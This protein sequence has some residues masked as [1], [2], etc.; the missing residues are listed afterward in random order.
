MGGLRNRLTFANVASALALFIAL[1]SGA[2]L[3]L[4]GKNSVNSGD[5]RNET[6][7]SADVRNGKLAPVDFFG[8]RAGARAYGVVQDLGGA[9]E[10]ARSRGVADVVQPASIGDP[11]G[12]VCISLNEQARRIAAPGVLVG[13]SLHV[14]VAENDIGLVQ[15]RPDTPNCRDDL[16]EVN[17]LRVDVDGQMVGLADDSFSFVIH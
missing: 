12:V 6:L 4:P 15:W 16:Y 13:D 2:A 9:V 3:A 1:G 10:V 7:K 8:E 14:G 11:T 5:V 17:V